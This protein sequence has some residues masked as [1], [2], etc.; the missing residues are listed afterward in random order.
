MALAAFAIL[1]PIAVIARLI[2]GRWLSAV[3]VFPGF[4][5][6]A[7][8]LPPLVLP[9]YT[10]TVRSYVWEAISCGAYLIGAATAYGLRPTEAMQSPKLVVLQQR[11]IKAVVLAGSVTGL[12]AAVTSIY[13]NGFHL[14]DTLSFDG[15]LEVGGTISRA[16]YE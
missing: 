7:G 12:V 5:L 2:A 4:W 13:S 8:V 1:A 16:R 10:V 15:L 3:A 6:I 9:N 11:P 14:A